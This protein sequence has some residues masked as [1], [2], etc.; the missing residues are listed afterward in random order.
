MGE[1]R[2][3]KGETAGP[4]RPGDGANVTSAK[5]PRTPRRRWGD[6]EVEFLLAHP[7]MG[8]REMA[9]ELG[10]TYGA[11]RNK[12]SQLGRYS[13]PPKCEYCRERPVWQ[14]SARARRMRMCHRC[15]NAEMGRRAKEAVED[16]RRRQREFKARRGRGRKGG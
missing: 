7:E 16:N 6:A 1:Q 4:L 12:R 15:F 5:N 9:C 14:E 8:G 2:P 3:R 10:R 11:V 13:G